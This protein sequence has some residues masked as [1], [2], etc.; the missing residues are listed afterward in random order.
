MATVAGHGTHRFKEFSRA[1]TCERGRST[2]ADIA[3]TAR[4]HM[5]DNLDD[6]ISI[7]GLSRALGVSERTLRY[8]FQDAFDTS[9]LQYLKALR[10]QQA[11]RALRQ[12][13][14]RRT[15]VRREALR[16]GFWHLSRFSAEYKECFGELPSVTLKAHPNTVTMPKPDRGDI[17]LG[18]QYLDR[19]A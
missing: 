1:D 13:S 17:A 9:P 4:A 2:R 14:P 7:R 18:Q 16:S 19:P 10:L 8:A 11:Q 3:F 12:A 5:L 15:T 6:S